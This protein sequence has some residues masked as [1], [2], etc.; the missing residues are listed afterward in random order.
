MGLFSS[1]K[2]KDKFI[3]PAVSREAREELFARGKESVDFPTRGIADLSE[4]ELE[5]ERQ[6]QAQLT[7][8][9]SPERETVIQ[10]ALRTATTPAN[11]AN[12]PEL[13]AIF[14]QIA[15]LGEIE[16]NRLG[17]GLQ[18]RGSIGSTPARDIL[19]RQLTATT[20]ALAR[21][22]APF[23]I[24]ARRAK[25]QA[26]RDVS[27]F[28][29]QREAETTGRLGV[30]G[31]VGALRRDIEQIKLDADLNKFLR[32]IQF[33]FQTQPNLLGAALVTPRIT[34]TGGGPSELQKV[35]SAISQIAPFVSAFSGAGSTQGTSVP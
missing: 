2:V 28:V 5:V 21:G 24:E 3:E 34:T 11:V 13:Q 6:A 7:A 23:L 1:P 10:E 25:S 12:L 19:G 29:G 15:E 31:A 35:S 26:G 18:I 16:A 27:T 4:T 9:P 22:A 33:R 20:E 32:D 30:G 14:K 17:R 8:G